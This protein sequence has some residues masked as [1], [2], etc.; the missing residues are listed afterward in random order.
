MKRS[1]WTRI[2]QSF[3][4]AGLL[5]AGTSAQAVIV[6]S[7]NGSGGINAY[8]LITAQQNWAGA[9]ANSQIAFPGAGSLPGSGVIGHLATITSQ[10]ESN[11]VKGLNGGEA[12]IGLTDAPG[13]APGAFEGGNQTGFPVP[14]QG[15]TP[16]AG[17]RGHGWAWVTGEALT[18][19]NWNGNGEPNNFNGIEHH[20]HLT[21]GNA[22]WND[23]DGAGSR[24]FIREWDNVGTANTLAMWKVQDI[25]TASTAGDF[26]TLA[27]NADPNVTTTTYHSTLNFGSGNDQYAG[28]DLFPQG[29]GD[30][31]MTRS[32][33]FIK[34]PTS[35]VYT[36][37]GAHDDDVFAQ[38]GTSFGNVTS[39]DGGAGGGNARQVFLTAGVY[40]IEVI[41]REGAGGDYLEF[42]MGAGVLP[43]GS[44]SLA[45]VGSG[46]HPAG[47]QIH[48]SADA[49]GGLTQQVA[50]ANV[51]LGWT[52]TVQTLANSPGLGLGGT[53]DNSGEAVALA[54]G[55]GAPEGSGTLQTIDLGT[56][57]FPGGTDQFVF[58]A[59]TYIDILTAEGT[60]TAALHVSSDDGFRLL[61]N[62]VTVSEFNSGTGDSNTISAMLN[63]KDNDLI[64][65][66]VFEQG[67]DEQARLRLDFDGL[68]STTSDRIFLGAA[69][70]PIRALLDPIIVPEPASALL[71][72]MGVL[73]IGAR[74]R[75]VA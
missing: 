74:R 41:H 3:C 30:N 51:P 58:Y 56:G 14:A 18:F 25:R 53:I 24:N 13:D 68:L 7:D 71:G 69:G 16:V 73:A 4:A 43:N 72:L 54:L 36:I 23:N 29:N 44:P 59:K 9:K 38:I 46:A 66:F 49:L 17:Q 19:H 5:M 50:V 65:L 48:Q 35:G 64:E 52:F 75:R 21:G 39:L 32:T 28:G 1:I 37:N 60:L 27:R 45:L 8:E 15:S 40:A 11:V 10:H 26:V 34:I 31:F 70:S 55:G 12:W 61:V 42:G 20:A 63:L 67:G 6:L 22:A 62:G 33:A 2:A 47:I 57:Q